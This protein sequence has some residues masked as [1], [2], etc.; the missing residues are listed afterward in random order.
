MR[1]F[2]IRRFAFAVLL[3]LCVA[4]ASFLLVHFAPGDFFT[5]FGV[6]DARA[7]AERAASGLDR[8]L[9][10][11]YA[12][13]LGHAARL[14][15]GTSLKFRRPVADLLY[16]R[17]RNTAI[18]GL[19]ALVFATGL[20]VPLGVYTG[21]QSRGVVRQ[22][23][24]AVST[25]LVAVPPFVA[26]LALTALAARTGWLARGGAHA[27]NLLVPALALALPMAAII[28]RMQSQ[29]MRDALRETFTH[30]ALARGLSRRRVVWKH[31]LRTSLGSLIGVYG[32][33]AAALLSGSFVVEIVTDWPGLGLLMADGLRAR[34]IF[35]VAGCATAGAVVLAA[36]VLASD[37][38]HVWLDPRMRET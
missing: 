34:D 38:L 21:A 12:T 35:L 2:I 33:L 10:Q 37:L 13:W 36:A 31:A 29:A 11:Q 32:V 18:L 14:D 28:E 30:A 5:E 25:T 3:V 17:V 7:Q 16:E 27:G 1:R 6:R 15:F 23:V 8:P 26:A 9:A 4:S 20:G 22:L 19:V 24:R